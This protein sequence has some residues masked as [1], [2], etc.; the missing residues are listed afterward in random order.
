MANF[1]TQKTPVNPDDVAPDK[2]EVRILAQL[3]SCG[4][5]EFRLA[6]GTV[7]LA[8]EHLTV[9]EIWYVVSGAGEMWRSQEG[10]EEITYLNPGISLTIPVGTRFQFLAAD[11]APLRVIG[12]TIPRWPGADEAQVREGHWPTC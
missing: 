6:A 2:S 12:V 11:G 9:D 8:V 10:R 1:A 3:E 7:S 4:M 5:A